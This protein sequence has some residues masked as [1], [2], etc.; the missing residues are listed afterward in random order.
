LLTHV[1]CAECGKKYNGKTGRSNTLNI[2]IAIVAAVVIGAIIGAI[3]G[4]MFVGRH[5]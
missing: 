2:V 4:R 1:R 3:G 5:R